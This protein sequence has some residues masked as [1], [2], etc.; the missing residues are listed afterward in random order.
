MMSVR[1]GYKKTEVGVIPEDWEVARIGDY[2]D[3]LDNKRIPLSSEVRANMQGSIPY[4]GANGVLD[5]I[6]EYIFDEEL[7]LLAEDGG[8][9][10][11][12]KTRPIA[13]MIVGK[14]WVN[15]HAHILRAKNG[16]N[17][18]LYYSLVHKN[19]TAYIN[20][21]T[22]AKLNRGELIK[23]PLAKPPL[24]EQQK[25]AAILASVDNK[26]EVIDAQIAKTE[27]LKKGLMQ[28]LLSE[29]IG[30][31]RAVKSD[32]NCLSSVGSEPEALCESTADGFKESEIGRIPKEWEV[33]SL[34]S[35]TDLIKDG[36]HGSHKDV[37]NGI[38][39]LSAKDI[40]N[41]KVLIPNDCRKVSFDD[42]N[43]IHKN[44]KI[45]NN[46]LL[47]TVVGTLGRIA[48]VKNYYKNFTL[49][50]SVAII[51]SSRKIVPEYLYYTCESEYF[52][53]QLKL[54]SNASAQAGVYLGELEKIKIP[55]PP[56]KEQKQIAKILS[57]TDDKLDTLR[58][59][60]E[61]YET[62][63]KGLMQKLL[64]GEVRV[65]V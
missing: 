57:T 17:H 62:L 21:G 54:R 5:Y 49:Q 35:C 52:Q 44:Y 13:Y 43:N 59:K 56:I 4:Y 14:S 53:K 48:L 63:K 60:K 11:D 40:D 20:G 18:F 12:Y 31:M 42:F 25:I 46:D 50:R 51:R 19:I 45:Q 55:I 23:I 16:Q 39:L 7:V 15:N 36:T 3:I 38:P 28:K 2:C 47:L 9:F 61:K 64:T 41:G 32:D 58:A 65:K 22:R 27:T 29:G 37:S 34:D 30:H 6:D 24:P 10:S 1:E 33:A 8:N 26:I